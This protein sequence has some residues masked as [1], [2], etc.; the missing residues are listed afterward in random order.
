MLVKP[1]E[2]IEIGF[3][4]LRYSWCEA[5]STGMNIREGL[6]FIELILIYHGDV[7]I[8]SLM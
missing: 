3:S 1:I 4:N 2:S 5:Y 6:T 8:L 7:Q